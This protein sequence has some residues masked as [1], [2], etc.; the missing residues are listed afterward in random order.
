MQVKYSRKGEA[1]TVDKDEHPRPQTDLAGLAKLRPVN[2]GGVTTA[3]N[4]SGRNDGAAFVLMMSADKA[5]E[6]G[7]E[8]MA[9]WICGMDAV[10][11]THLD[12]YKRQ[13]QY[14]R[15]HPITPRKKK[16]KG[17]T[18]GGMER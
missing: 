18:I 12:V 11:Y 9:K 16:I 2:E 17:K 10:S 7:Y 1:V 6:L 3:G 15:Q 8:P 13:E 5:K 4:A 14:G